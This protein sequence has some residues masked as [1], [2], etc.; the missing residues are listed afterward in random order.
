MAALS[1]MKD[2][3]KSLEKMDGVSQTSE[4][5]RFWIDSGNYVLNYILSG[6]FHHAIPQGRVTGLAGPSGSGKSFIQCNVARQAQTDLDASVVMI[7]TENALDDSFTSKIGIDPDRPDYC[8]ISAITIGQVVKICSDFVKG[9][10]KDYGEDPD[11][12]KVLLVI[13]SL[14]MLL[15]DTEDKHFSSGENKGDQGQRAK[16]I[17]AFL[18]NMV[19]Q[20]KNLNIAMVITHQVYAATQEMILKGQSDGNWVINGAVRYS[21]S[22]LALLTKLKLKDGTEI[23]GIKMKCQAVKTRFTKPFQDVVIE[24]PYDTGMNP[25]SGLAEV[26][27]ALGILEKRG[28]YKR[29]VGTETQFYA[30]NIGEH[31]DEIFERIKQLENASLVMTDALGLE[32]EMVDTKKSNAAKRRENALNVLDEDDE[33]I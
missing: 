11:A 22:H 17:K 4:P 20:I 26:A 30:K 14:D 33:V 10:K 23:T 29:I 7:D 3:S 15:T 21:L 16:Q 18:R 5:P 6:D 32:E 25:Y 8:Y 19:Q 12:P 27:E 24:V 1:F 31:K 2:F 13:D 9:Y 28:S